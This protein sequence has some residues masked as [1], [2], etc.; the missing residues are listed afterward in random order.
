MLFGMSVVL[1]GIA[2]AASALDPTWL[3]WIAVV[4]GADC[5]GRV[6]PCSHECYDAIQ[7]GRDRLDGCD[8]GSDVAARRAIMTTG[9]RAFLQPHRIGP[10]FRPADGAARPPRRFLARQGRVPAPGG[11]PLPRPS[12]RGVGDEPAGRRAHDLR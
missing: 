11:D 2:L 8:W 7:S 6:L 5:S 9:S 3:G 12:C 10:E 1:F 4:G